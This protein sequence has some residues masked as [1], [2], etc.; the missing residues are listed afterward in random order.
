M[1]QYQHGKQHGS[2]PTPVAK[3][4]IVDLQSD[5]ECRLEHAPLAHVEF[6]NPGF[7][8]SVLRNYEYNGA[9]LASKGHDSITSSGMV[10][11]E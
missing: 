4:S 8:I 11:I 3:A 9:A 5:N 6:A 7:W 10:F 1:L 2:V